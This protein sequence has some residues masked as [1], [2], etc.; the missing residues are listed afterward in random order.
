LEYAGTDSYSSLFEVSP[1]T[2]LVVHHGNG[3]DGKPA[4]VGMFMTVDVN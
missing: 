3:P 1:N 4:V 2:I